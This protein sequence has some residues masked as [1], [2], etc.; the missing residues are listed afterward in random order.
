MSGPGLCP[1]LRSGSGPGSGF[2]SGRGP[3]CGLHDRRSR[4]LR[5]RLDWGGGRAEAARCVAVARRRGAA[6]RGAARRGSARRGA[7]GAAAQRRGAA[8]W[9]RSCGAAAMGV[10]RRTWVPR[11][12]GW[13]GCGRGVGGAWVLVGS[14]EAQSQIRARSRVGR[15]S[16]LGGEAE[17]NGSG[18]RCRCGLWS[19]RVL[20]FTLFRSAECAKAKITLN[21]QNTEK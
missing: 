9:A 3:G 18:W 1:G 19:C 5:P 10:W 15:Y 8:G 20:Q 12:G 6:W 17:K 13:R 7:G 11:R 21:T 14:V 2:W 16:V 4:V